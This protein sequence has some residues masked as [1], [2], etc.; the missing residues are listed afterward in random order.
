MVAHSKREYVTR[1]EYLA[2]ERK[3]TT[4]SEY[5]DGVVVAMAGA[6]RQHN[7]IT[8]DT[9]RSLGNQ[10]EGA[11]CE[12]FSSDMRVLVPECNRYFY[13]DVVVVCGEAR[14]EDA[15][16]DTLENPSLIIEVLSESTEHADRRLKSDCYR[17]LPSLRTY[18]LIAQDEP[19][20]ETFTRQ[21]NGVWGYEAVSGREAVMPL[22]A[23][24]CMLRLSDV[25]A[26]VEFPPPPDADTPQAE[27]NA[28]SEP[29]R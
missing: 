9:A 26:R 29:A 10:L 20:I 7:R 21:D 19:R 8:F 1:Q 18:V 3:A 2:G 14:F 17:T 15:E 11:P 5:H 4:K 25:Y 27:S 16:L 22:P 12:P 6:S 23:I 28:S 24:G 13:P